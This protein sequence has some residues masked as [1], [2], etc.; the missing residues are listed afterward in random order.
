LCGSYGIA[1]NHIDT[2]RKDASMGASR[3]N[4]RHYGFALRI[5]I[6]NTCKIA[7]NGTQI[8]LYFL[9]ANRMGVCSDAPT[10]EVDAR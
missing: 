8:G 6:F 10:G 1:G 2:L 5:N 3:S 9:S 4:V 7:V